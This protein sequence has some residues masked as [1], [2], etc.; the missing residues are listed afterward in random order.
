MN[1]AT[2]STKQMR[3]NFDLVLTAMAS[4][5]PLTLMYRS[6]PLAQI[7][8]IAPSLPL[9]RNFSSKQINSWI[10]SDKLSSAQEQQIDELIN[11]L[12]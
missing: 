3:E 10:K 8:P 9:G 4:G 5:Q 2:I 12:P 11:R 7:K 6:Q 1:T